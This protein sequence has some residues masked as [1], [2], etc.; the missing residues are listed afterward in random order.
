M[1][2]S[3][4]VCK[5]TPVCH[6]MKCQHLSEWSHLHYNQ[7]CQQAG[8]L[9][10]QYT[11]AGGRCPSLYSCCSA[12]IRPS[13]N[14]EICVFCLPVRLDLSL[15]TDRAFVGG[16]FTGHFETATS[17]VE[18]IGSLEKPN[19]RRSEANLWP[20]FRIQRT[21]QQFISQIIS[22]THPTNYICFHLFSAT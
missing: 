8:L 7:T 3:D 12:K 13:G 16:V 15:I 4:M 10:K 20:Q 9:N 19:H 11:V 2:N 1:P 22:I 6:K 18:Q 5:A 21:T 17:S 14:K